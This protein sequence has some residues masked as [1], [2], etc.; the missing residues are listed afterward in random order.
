MVVDILSEETPRRHQGFHHSFEDAAKSNPHAIAIE[1]P[2]SGSDPGSKWSYEKVNEKAC[3]LSYALR[4]YGVGE[5]II[6]IYLPR[7][8][9]KLFIAQLAILKVKE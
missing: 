2:A 3:Q 7:V 5:R 6:V 8:D 4:L 9:E 1:V